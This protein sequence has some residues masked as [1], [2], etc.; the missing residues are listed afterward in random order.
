MTLGFIIL[1]K[2]ADLWIN[3]YKS[4]RKHFPDNSIL[5]VDDHSKQSLITQCELT[6]CH[7]QLAELSNCSDILPYYYFYKLRP[8]DRA[9]V[10]HDNMTIDRWY[11]FNQRVPVQYL[12]GVRESR[13]NTI[14]EMFILC[15]L[16][17]WR[18]LMKYYHQREWR[19]C[20]KSSMLIDLDFLDTL[21]Q[22]YGLFDVLPF[23]KTPDQC[24]AFITV[25]CVLCCY[26][27]GV[28]NSIL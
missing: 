22:K 5:I 26:T 19:Q 17:E 3:C 9:V 28:V 24:A 8:F 20:G 6:N 25:L 15:R 12:W 11:P 18:D 2:H 16:R 21:Q 23:I 14:N 10:L 13:K 7:V 27:L 1:R 4:I